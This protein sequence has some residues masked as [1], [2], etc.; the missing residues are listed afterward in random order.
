MDNFMGHVRH[1]NVIKNEID[2]RKFVLINFT[3][4]V[5]ESITD[6]RN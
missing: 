3:F 2:D 1:L 5:S 4:I 6:V